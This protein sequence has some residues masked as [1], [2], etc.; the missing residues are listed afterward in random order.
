MRWRVARSSGTLGALESGVNDGLQ[1]ANVNNH[2][3]KTM[4]KTS[5]I[6]PDFRAQ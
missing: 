4:H 6:T 3:Q 1:A 5:D 2:P